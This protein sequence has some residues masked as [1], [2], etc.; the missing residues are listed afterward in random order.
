M[1]HQ[2]LPIVS[3]IAILETIALLT[4]CVWSVVREMY[5]R[6]L[7]S[8][9]IQV[10]KDT[11]ATLSD[12]AFT[13]KTVTKTVETSATV[14]WQVRS[15]II[16]ELIRTETAVLQ[17]VAALTGKTTIYNTPVGQVKSNQTMIGENNG[18]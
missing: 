7:H 3:T 12:V 16:T 18:G 10:V 6:K 9:N 8:E 14:Q 15:E 13:I 2:W 4:L 11:T 5:V 1:D 17:A